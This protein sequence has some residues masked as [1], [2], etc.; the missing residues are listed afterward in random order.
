MNDKI[1][2]T[3]NTKLASL[4]NKYNKGKITEDQYYDLLEELD[5]W[6]ESQYN[7][8]SRTKRTADKRDISWSD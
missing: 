2:S 5:L 3:Y 1:E 8:E 7:I 4:N 6:K